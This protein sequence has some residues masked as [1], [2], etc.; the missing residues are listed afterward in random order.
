M[1]IPEYYVGKIASDD[2]QSLAPHR[3]LP[4][5]ELMVA[6]AGSCWLRVP[7]TNA[8]IFA[9]LPL[10]GRWTVDGGGLLTRIGRRVAELRLETGEWQPV[11]KMLPVGPPARGGVGM[12]PPAADFMLEIEHEEQP[13][14]ALLARWVD[15]AHWA[16]TAFSPR[17]ASLQFAR[18]DDDRVL[19][20]GKPVPPI[21]GTGFHRVGRLLLPGGYRLPDHVW[22][23][24]VE[25][26]L[27]LGANRMA[28]IHSDGSYESVAEENFIPASRAAVRV[29]EGDPISTDLP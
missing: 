25:E 26:S 10:S 1:T 3:A 12:I 17:L 27:G 15:F 13:A 20:T 29:T 23:Q 22:P 24:L 7:L 9:V 16:D 11:S 6:E 2:L 4:G 5:W 18:C 8:A 21:R 28:L 19:V 14:E